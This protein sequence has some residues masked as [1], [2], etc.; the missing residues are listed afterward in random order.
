[1]AKNAA[2][3]TCR[4]AQEDKVIAENWRDA[5]QNFDIMKLEREVRRLK[6]MRLEER[7]KFQNEKL[8]ILEEERKEIEKKARRESMTVVQGLQQELVATQR[9]LEDQL[10]TVIQSLEETMNT[11]QPLTKE[12]LMHIISKARRG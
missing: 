11:G 8:R 10:T 12:L 5:D 2:M 1:M 4:R 9:K 3:E 6:R 7:T